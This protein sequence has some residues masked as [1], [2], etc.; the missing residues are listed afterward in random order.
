MPDNVVITAASHVGPTG[1]AGSQ[2]GYT[3]WREQPD[4]PGI[5]AGVPT[6]SWSSL[7]TAAC[8]RF[9]RMDTLSKIALMAVERLNL[10]FAGWA[11]DE[12]TT[13][14]VCLQT[15]YG[16]VSTDV[17]FLETE[18]PSIFVYTLAST[19]IGEI[20]I[21]HGLQ[22]P[23]L[24]LMCQANQNANALTE[25]AAWVN[26]GDCAGAICLDCEAVDARAA[27]TLTH[28]GVPDIKIDWQASALYVETAGSS[29]R[30]S[31]EVLKTWQPSMQIRGTA[32]GLSE[33]TILPVPERR[34]GQE[35]GLTEE[36]VAE[37]R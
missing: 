7:F 21:R 17:E 1:C 24:C 26:S 14:G 19:A 6:L 36:G 22:G 32:E 34:D 10:E 9:G 15:S 23:V 37:A 11:A 25:A 33:G 20:C 2:G 31:A 18:S 3:A 4:R 29:T 13:I 8:P 12:K 35:R 30:R 28:A 5:R 16:S 27:E